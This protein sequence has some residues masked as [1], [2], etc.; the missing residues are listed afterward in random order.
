[1]EQ[2]I[3]RRSAGNRIFLWVG[4]DGIE[5]VP[6]FISSRRSDAVLFYSI[7]LPL[8]FIVGLRRLTA[9]ICV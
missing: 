5:G 8:D 2:H 9:A 7:L 4:S 6:T 3:G 1:M